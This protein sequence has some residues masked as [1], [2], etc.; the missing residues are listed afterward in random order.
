MTSDSKLFPPRPKWEEWGYRPD[1]YS[2]WLKGP[3]KPIEQLYAD[4]GVQALPEGERR[5]AQPPYDKLPLPRADIPVGIILSREAT[6]YISEDDIPTVT[7]TDASGKPL[8]IKVVNE[9]G[10]KE[11]VEVVGPAIALPLYE[12]RMIGQFDF[13]EKGWVSG[14]GRSA[15]W[16]VIPW[17]YKSIQPQ[18]LMGSHV[19]YNARMAASIMQIKR[20]YGHKLRTSLLRRG[21]NDHLG[22]RPLRRVAFMDIT[23][24]TNERT[25]IAAEATPFPYGNSSPVFS[26]RDHP[27]LLV[28]VLNSFTYDGVIRAKCS[29]VHLNWFVVEESAL[30]NVDLHI[31]KLLIY[32]STR[33][34]SCSV[35]NPVVWLA[36][37]VPWR[38]YWSVTPHE[39]I[40]V[41]SQLEAIW[42]TV[43]GLSRNNLGHLLSNCDY[44]IE[45]F[46]DKG[47][48]AS[49]PPK[50]FWRVDR[51]KNPEHRHTVLSLVAF[52]DLQEE[53]VACGGD[54]IRGIEAFC[55]QNDGEGWMLPET[56]RLADYGLGHDERAKEHQPVRECFGPRFY[57][58]QLAQSPEES[59]KECHLHAR[60]L[61]GEVGYQA[62]LNDMEGRTTDTE[63]AGESKDTPNGWL[64]DAEDAPLFQ[65]DK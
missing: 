57:D 7:F 65:M 54:V 58:W 20:D 25:M 22:L 12:G 10:D 11:E 9:D 61:L 35:T 26:C 46:R 18:Y 37:R 23:S 27:N 42:A 2:R 48:S 21:E 31:K 63:N 5:C 60:H 62:L 4:L 49:L 30:P 6:H 39:R 16:Q 1:E 14:S 33:L 29:G 64:F 19:Y 15:V 55:D 38:A 51:D 44:P 47:F 24:A 40:R 34:C 28:G 43:F 13:S 56:L 50:G 8:K 45:R 3:W 59:W 36:Y 32:L 41:R 53:I 52:H 17:E